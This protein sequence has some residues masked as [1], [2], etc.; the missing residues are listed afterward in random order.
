MVMR[1]YRNQKFQVSVDTQLSGSIW[2]C[3]LKKKKKNF[4]KSF[5]FIGMSVIIMK[6]REREKEKKKFLVG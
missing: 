5:L 3:S 4:S 1:I 6:K 2:W